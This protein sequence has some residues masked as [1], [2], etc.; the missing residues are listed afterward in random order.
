MIMYGQHQS[1]F[2]QDVLRTRGWHSIH[3]LGQIPKLFPYPLVGRNRSRGLG[4]A[5]PSLSPGQWYELIALA[6]NQPLAN[7]QT[8]YSQTAS[9]SNVTNLDVIL[10]QWP[11][12]IAHTG[13]LQYQSGGVVDAPAG[14]GH[15]YRYGGGYVS[16]AQTNSVNQWAVP[17]QL[18][19]AQQ[20]ATQQ[21]AST[22]QYQLAMSAPVYTQ[23][24]NQAALIQAYNAANPKA[25]VVASPTPAAATPL[26]GA[27]PSTSV[28]ASSQQSVSPLPPGGAVLIGSQ[29][30]T[31][32]TTGADWIPGIPNVALLIAAG[33]AAVALMMAGRR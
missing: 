21:A 17:S 22:A 10:G 3:G 9:G 24:Q 30:T 2:K 26:A 23:N 31:P 14:S 8:Y 16:W 32:T 11:G 33:G 6:E 7:V 20:I 15:Y 19:T 29:G 5:L 28:Q 1:T 4:Q 13:Y 25:L 12:G 18:P 27:A